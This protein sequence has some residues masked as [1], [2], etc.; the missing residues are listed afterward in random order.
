MKPCNIILEVGLETP[1]CPI[2]EHKIISTTVIYNHFCLKMG[3]FQSYFGRIKGK[4]ANCPNCGSNDKA[5]A[6]FE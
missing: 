5:V 6:K 3:C 1:P 2:P 4:V